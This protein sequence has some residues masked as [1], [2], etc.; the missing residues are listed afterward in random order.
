MMLKIIFKKINVL[1]KKKIIMKIHDFLKI[2]L[3]IKQE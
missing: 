3:I 1:N 2:L